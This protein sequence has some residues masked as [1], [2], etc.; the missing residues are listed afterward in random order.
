MTIST[1]ASNI[2]TIKPISHPN[3][4]L[5]PADARSAGDFFAILQCFNIK[6]VANRNAIV[7]LYL[8]KPIK[9]IF[10]RKADD[11]KII[12]VGCGKVGHSLAERLSHENHDITVIDTN[13]SVLAEAQDTLDI[14][15]VDGNGAALDTLKRAGA[16]KA[17]ILIATTNA[18]ETNLLST[19]S[20]KKLGCQRTIARVRN[21][22]YTKQVIFLKDELG[23]S[24]VVNPELTAA[25]EIYRM[26]QFP[27]FLKRDTFSKGRVELVELKIA[28]DSRLNGK[29]IYEA[30]S[31]LGLRVLICAVER[32]NEVFIPNGGFTLLAGDKITVTAARNNLVA[33]IKSLGLMSRKIKNVLIVGCSRIAEYL[34]EELEK[35]GISVTVIE[36]DLKRCEDF[37]L[38]FPKALVINGNASRRGFLE[39]AGVENADAVISLTGIDEENLIISM[40]CSHVGVK[41]TVTKID[42][43]EYVRLF[44]DKEIGSVVCPKDLTASEIVRYVRAVSNRG[45]EGSVKTLHHIVNGKAEAIEFAV[46]DNVK[47]TDIPLAKLDIKQNILITCIIRANQV[48]IPNGTDVIRSGDSVIIVTTADHP[49]SNLG[50]I[51]RSDHIED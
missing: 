36:K 26:V 49:V 24:M 40:Y 7:I 27:S 29:K 51:F 37:S 14:L 34:T 41:K 45:D 9:F 42:R 8:H 28:E 25:H 13:L 47:Y 43:N 19:I 17:D 5:L 23:L 22:Q 50:E 39:S 20:A 32:G 12:I 31:T 44:A 2:R 15:A 10:I 3:D 30:A 33:L 21:P 6:R 11:M 35:G 4:P 46:S 18:D 48:I 16:D 1:V 38:R